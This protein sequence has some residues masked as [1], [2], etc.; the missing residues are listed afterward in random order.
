MAIF[1]ILASSAL[2]RILNV[3][4]DS[5]YGYHTINVYI[6]SIAIFIFFKNKIS[7]IKINTKIKQAIT[8][9]S[10]NVF[11]IYLTHDIL[12]I[13][14]KKYNAFYVTNST[15]FNNLFWSIIIFV[16]SYFIVCIIKKIP[17]INKY[18]T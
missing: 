5:F 11:G 16:I 6:T 2:S 12:I 9:I 14:I 17:K 10:D 8:K 4:T 15:I 7:K 18:I 13:L 1:T 3:P